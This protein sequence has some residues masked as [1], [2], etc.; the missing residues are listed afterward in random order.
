[1]KGMYEN[2]RQLRPIP[3]SV[4]EAV[5]NRADGACE[6][7]G[8]DRPLELHHRTY[9]YDARPDVERLIFGLEQPDDLLA[10]CRDCHLARHVVNGEFYAD[11]EEADAERDY[12]DHRLG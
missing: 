7:C 4:R 1:M 6:D 11:P 10:L 8:D 9:Y 2:E 12:Q 3:Q 5:L